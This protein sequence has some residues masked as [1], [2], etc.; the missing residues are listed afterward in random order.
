MIKDL[1]WVEKYRPKEFGDV[2]GLNYKFDSNLPNILL[3]GTCGIGKTTLAKIICNKLAG[4]VLS[5]NASSE[6]GIDVIR[7]KVK[8]FASTR[9]MD[10]SKPKVIHLDEADGLTPDAQNVLRNLIE[11][12]S[13]NTRFIFTCN[14][15]GKIIEPIRSRCME[16]NLSNPDKHAILSKLDEIAKLEEVDAKVVPEIIESNYPDM[17]SMIM[18]LQHYKMFG[19]VPTTHK[20]MAG[21]VYQ[22]I[23][24]GKF[25]DARKKWIAGDADYKRLLIDIYE[26]MSPEEIIKNIDELAQANYEMAMG[27]FPEISFA[28]AMKR[29]SMKR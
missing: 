19:V 18:S 2:I 3:A 7:G 25:I 1:L 12:Y 5:M 10:I 21:E 4:D 15:V 22:L 24:D 13:N 17:R 20:I 27:A 29:I 23:M 14:N 28:A 26:L 9:G 11:E 6:R 8:E 16:I